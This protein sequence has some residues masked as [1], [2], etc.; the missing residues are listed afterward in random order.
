[1]NGYNMMGKYYQH[2]HM[3]M[4]DNSCCNIQLSPAIGFSPVQ[5]KRVTITSN[6]TREGSN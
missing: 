2:R 1:M 3:A 4:N 6:I 5:A